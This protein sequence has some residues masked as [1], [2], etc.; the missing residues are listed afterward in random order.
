LE[1]NTHGKACKAPPVPAAVP[2]GCSH[3]PVPLVASS[4]G[5]REVSFPGWSFL[6]NFKPVANVSRKG[7]AKPREDGFAHGDNKLRR[8][9]GEQGEAGTFLKR[10]NRGDGLLLMCTVELD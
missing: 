7:V 9:K 2:G 10:D 5:L 1:Q 6:G 3:L 4:Q 8:A